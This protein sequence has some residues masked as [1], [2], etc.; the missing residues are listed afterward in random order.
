GVLHHSIYI[1]GLTSIIPPHAVFGWNPSTAHIFRVIRRMKSS[2]K[3]HSHKHACT[4]TRTNER[5]NETTA[6]NTT[7]N[8]NCARSPATATFILV[9]RIG[10]WSLLAHANMNAWHGIFQ[11]LDGVSFSSRQPLFTNETRPMKLAMKRAC[12]SD[13]PLT[14]L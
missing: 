5:R 12:R 8:E 4:H 1:N 3:K 11:L 6:L 14:L 9:W 2:L 7:S 10:R 13:L